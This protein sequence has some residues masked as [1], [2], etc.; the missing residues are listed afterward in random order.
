MNRRA[1]IQVG[2]TVLVALSVLLMGVTWLKDFNLQRKVTVWHVSFPE[3]GG[4]GD[5]DEV[6]VNGIRKGVVSKIALVGDQVVVDLSLSSDVRLTTSSRVTIRN[7]GMMGEKVIAV[8]LHMAGT[9]RAPADTIAGSYELG[10][11]E[12][13]A[14]LGG[15][16]TAIDHVATELNRLA[17]SFDRGGELEKTLVNLEQTSVDLRGAVG[18][19]R[20]LL[21]A[22]LVDAAVATKSARE[23][24]TGREEQYKRVLDSA[25]RTT[26]N[27]E[28]LSVRLDSLRAVAQSIG[29]KVDHGDGDLARLVNDHQLYDDVRASLKSMR[30]VLDD[31]KKNPKKYI[32]V[33]VF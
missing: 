3:T 15:T 9:R 8:D 10:I 31:L 20:T 14:N 5:A 16:M 24:T 22:V 18:E 2:L 23:L 32:N 11:S 30:D 12:V 27:L 6:Q 13:V 26:R 7:V 29:S 1:E 4:L 19:N 21:H 25:E 17:A 33:H 28:Q